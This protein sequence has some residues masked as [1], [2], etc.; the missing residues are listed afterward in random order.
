MKHT[1]TLLALLSTVALSAQI[2]HELH[3]M[4][5]QFSPS[6]L[7]IGL[8]DMIHIIFDDA[9]HTF[10]QVDQATWLSNGTTPLIGGFNMGQGTPQPGTDFTITP[11]ALGAIYYVCQFHVD[12]GMKGSIAVVSTG[13]EEAGMQSAYQLV[14]NPA[15]TQVKLMTDQAASVL[16]DVF[17]ATGKWCIGTRAQ[18]HDA[19]DVT[20][21]APGSYTAHIRDME[22]TL[23]SRQ[24]LVITR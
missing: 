20:A 4:D 12:M 5:N 22:G 16:V 1:T 10:T 17:D 23:L 13:M 21:L 24:R 9:D 6:A 2:T 7:T 8:G 19:M 3:V 18:S 15:A 14:P 11:Q